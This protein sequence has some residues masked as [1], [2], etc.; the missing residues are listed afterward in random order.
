MADRPPPTPKPAATVILA[1]QNAERLQYYLLKRRGGSGF[2]AG[3]YVF[4]GGM[5]DA[6]DTQTDFWWRYIDLD[7]AEVQTHLG[8]PLLTADAMLPNAVAAI[9]E[10]LEEAGVLL[11]LPTDGLPFTPAYLSTLR[12]QASGVSG[13]LN[14]EAESGRWRLCVG[15]LRRWTHWITPAQMRPRFD[16]RF[17]VA[18]MPDG[19]R[20]QPDQIETTDG[21]WTTAREALKANLMG[22]QCLSPPTLVTLHQLLPF[23]NLS[24]LLEST[25]NRPWGDLIEPRQIRFEG[26]AIVLEPWDPQYARQ[27]IIVDP[28]QLECKV[29]PVGESFS[30]IWFNGESWR[31]VEQ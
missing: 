10:T 6:A 21:C 26:G 9:R 31:P 29:L 28:N 4:P 11:A 18:E 13:F 25:Q 5:V 20:C 24:A 1:R 8:D 17:F 7:P 3:F 27:N 16:T 23:T 30:R 19:Q 14:A 22:H 15:A 12:P 2:M